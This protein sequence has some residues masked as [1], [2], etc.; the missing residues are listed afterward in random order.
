MANYT[1]NP[2]ERF[3][4]ICGMLSGLKLGSTSS[5]DKVNVVLKPIGVGGS[6]KIGLGADDIEYVEALACPGGCVGGPLTTE[7]SFSA[8]SKIQRIC[9]NIEKDGKPFNHKQNMFWDS[10]MVYRPV[11]NLD[12]DINEAMRKMNLI[13]ELYESFPKLDCGSCGSPS[14]RAL[15]EDIVRGYAKET[16]CIFKLRDLAKEVLEQEETH[17]TDEK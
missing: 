1:L 3:A 15:A 2:G 14:C 12:P 17:K 4:L 8:R 6:G 16:D 10:A 5:R 13:E 11:M 9:R 7:N